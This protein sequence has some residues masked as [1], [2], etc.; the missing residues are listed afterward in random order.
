[1]S[2]VKLSEHVFC[3][4]PANVF[5]RRI[6]NPVK[7]LRWS[8]LQ[9]YFT[10]VNYIR[11]TL[12]LKCWTEFWIRLCFCIMNC[13]RGGMTQVKLSKRLVVLLLIEFSFVVFCESLRTSQ[14]WKLKSSRYIAMNFCRYQKEC[15]FF[16]NVLL[17]TKFLQELIEV[18]P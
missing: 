13:W 12:H 18:I 5:L 9:R 11:K 3:R 10:A 2:L 14:A 6:H 15:S 8:V 17:P 16:H 1:M 4:T 7:H